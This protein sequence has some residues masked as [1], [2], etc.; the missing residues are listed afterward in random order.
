MEATSE[1]QEVMKIAS[2]IADAKEEDIPG[3]LIKLSGV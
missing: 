3:F 1:D 2:N